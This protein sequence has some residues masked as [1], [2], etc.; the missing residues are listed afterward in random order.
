MTGRWRWL[1]VAG[2]TVSL[3]LPVATFLVV[4]LVVGWRLQVVESGS[5]EPVYPVGALVIVRPVDPSDVRVGMPLAF[6]PDDGRPLVT[7]R[8]IEVLERS[9]GLMFRT[10]GDA[11][12][13]P[14]PDAVPARAVRG[15]GAWAIPQL[16]RVVQWLAWPRGFLLLVL[17]PGV[18][19]AVTEAWPRVRRRHEPMPA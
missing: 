10:Q 18:M 6:E 9:S 2:V 4:A 16:G 1:P 15:Q 19:L 3:L 8:V 13:R 14:D 17:A 7:H 5:M 12:A 11:N